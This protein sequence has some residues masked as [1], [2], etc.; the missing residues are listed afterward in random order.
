[1]LEYMQWKANGKSAAH[2][3]YRRKVNSKL[4]EVTDCFIAFFFFF[5]FLSRILEFGQYNWLTEELVRGH[6]GHETGNCHPPMGTSLGLYSLGLLRNKC[7]K[8]D[9]EEELV[10]SFTDFLSFPPFFSQQIPTRGS[11]LLLFSISCVTSLFFS[12]PP[13]ATSEFWQD[14]TA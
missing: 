6:T 12:A 2:V 4:L 13:Y 7:S 14:T 9:D 3:H 5:Y 11:S 10:L 1:M 8:H